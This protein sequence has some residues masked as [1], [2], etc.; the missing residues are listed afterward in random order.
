M[1]VKLYFSW[2]G[3]ILFLSCSTIRAETKGIDIFG[4]GVGARPLA[5]GK[6][7]VAVADDANTIF[8]NPAGIT[9]LK[10]VE[11]TAQY[12]RY[13]EE[14]NYGFL[15]LAIPGKH[16]GLGFGA[17]YFN[18]GNIPVTK[19][20]SGG[21]II[22]SQDSFGVTNLCFLS[23][24]SLKIVESLRLGVS[25]RYMQENLEEE[26]TSGYSFDAGL[27][28]GSQDEVLS[29][30]VI[31][32]NLYGQKNRIRAEGDNTVFGEVDE[33]DF[34]LPLDLQVGLAL[35][36][37]RTF[38]TFI[39]RMV[40]SATYRTRKQSEFDKGTVNLG[41]ELFLANFLALRAG[42]TKSLAENKNGKGYGLSAG[43]GLYSKSFSMDYA[44]VP[45]EDLGI[46]HWVSLNLKFAPAPPA[47]VVA[48][49]LPAEAPVVAPAPPVEEV[50]PP[51]PPVE[52]P[53]EKPLPVVP[54]AERITMAIMDLQAQGVSA[55]ESLVITDLLK[56]AIIVTNAFRIVERGNIQ[57]VMG[58]LGFQQTGC[59]EQECAIKI[60]KLLNAKKIL[61]GT[62]GKL[63]ET[64]II[65]IRMVDVEK[66][67][68][69]YSDKERS[70]T[71]EETEIAV[72]KLAQKLARRLTVPVAP[73]AE[74][75]PPE[76]PP[77]PPVEK[78][79]K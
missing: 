69:E 67:E 78:R 64:F 33:V 6:S 9:N 21:Q 65:T 16:L 1:K 14:T 35:R 17:M 61:I 76:V 62:V 52:V 44:F 28:I 37:F 34:S 45:H 32:R 10:N 68:V 19:I 49:Q 47:P 73:P 27:L 13:F 2:I 24:L 22:E 39:N 66:G 23:A 15:G 79:K 25:A 12:S 20:G 7:F 18:S 36:P 63:G 59:T 5:L 60:G 38:R 55:T 58:E 29:L 41:A 42:Y 48:P 43:I 4:M 11:L 51:A 70:S 75:P 56:N 54:P 30:G 40:L 26:S 71:I 57:Q 8:W 31:A 77:Q 72:E 3:L 50:P 53:V 46:T 74:V